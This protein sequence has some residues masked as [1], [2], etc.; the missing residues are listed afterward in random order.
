[1]NDKDL[2]SRLANGERGIPKIPDSPDTRHA[3]AQPPRPRKPGEAGKHLRSISTPVDMCSDDPDTDPDEA[4]ARPAEQPAPPPA[5]FPERE[6]LIKHMV[7]RF[8]GWKL[9]ENFNPDGG[10]SFKPT[11]NEHTAYPMKHGPTGTNLFDAMQAEGMIRYMLEGEAAEPSAPPQPAE[12]EYAHVHPETHPYTQLRPRKP[13]EGGKHLRSISV[14]VDM[15]SDDPDSDPEDAAEPSVEA[16]Q[17]MDKARAFFDKENAAV[18]GILT[19]MIERNPTMIP[20][21]MATFAE[22]EAAAAKREGMEEAARH[23]LHIKNGLG[24][25][26]EEAL[27]IS[28]LYEYTR[29]VLKNVRAALSKEQP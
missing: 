27:W 16:R 14:P 15:T 13:G 19:P 28:G 18:G 17:P 6:K 26:R 10:I 7:S 12:P 11:F 25:H 2:Q 21:L 9:P 29:D 23:Y 3:Q 22:Q 5:D 4:V 8:L 20:C 24:E 1:M